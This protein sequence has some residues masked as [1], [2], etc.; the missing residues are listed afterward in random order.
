[1]PQGT[2]TV[3]D[4]GPP[5]GTESF[6]CAP[7]P[8]G[9]RSFSEIDTAV[10]APH[11]EIVDV[12]VDNDWRIARVRIDT[13]EHDVLLE[14]RGDVLTGFRDRRPI[15]IERWQRQPQQLAPAGRDLEKRLQRRTT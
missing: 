1:M 7:G 3:F 2:Y 4:D 8:M 13:G 14:P 12:A 15:E 9:W 11:H 10:P 6:R 5:V